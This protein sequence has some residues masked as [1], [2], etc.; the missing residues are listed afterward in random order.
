M[1]TNCQPD[2]E[3]LAALRE[4]IETYGQEGNDEANEW[5]WNCLSRRTVAYSCGALRRSGEPAIHNHDEAEFI[6]CQR[7]ADEAA[8]LMADVLVGMGSEADHH[9]TPFFIVAS[10]GADNPQTLDADTLR[11][12]FGGTIYP[13]AEVIVEPL[14]ARGQWWR[15]VVAV[16]SGEEEDADEYEDGYEDEDAREDAD[17][18]TEVEEEDEEN[19]SSGKCLAPWRSL[20]E[21]FHNQTPLRESAFVSIGDSLLDDEN[22][23]SVFPRLAV[24][25]TSAGSIVG[26]VGVVVY[27]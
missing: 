4:C 25:L 17:I 3:R 13:Q 1:I 5:P 27:T 18:D 11:A 23:A 16:C 2:E 10:D 20:M 19:E 7:L 8:E 26:I 9:F 22:G 12:A 21:W 6:L 15:T 24:G 14:Q